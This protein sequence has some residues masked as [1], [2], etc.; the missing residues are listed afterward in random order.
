MNFTLE[1]KGPYVLLKLRGRLDATSSPALDEKIDELLRKKFYRLLI[2]FSHVN[3]LSSA[4][5]RFLL[6]ATKRYKSQGGQLI[7]YSVADEVMEIIKM[8]GFEKI[9]NL[10]PNEKKAIEDLAT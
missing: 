9:L 8:A 5:L 1:E 10:S 7:I 3:Y 2:D 4:G 6:S